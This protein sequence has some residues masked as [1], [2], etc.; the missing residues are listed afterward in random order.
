MLFTESLL[1][2]IGQH[3]DDLARRTL[4]ITE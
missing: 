2:E 1:D 3:T 4:A